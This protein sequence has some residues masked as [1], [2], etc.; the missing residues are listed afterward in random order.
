VVTTTQ[1]ALVANHITAAQ[2]GDYLRDHS[3]FLDTHPELLVGLTPPGLRTGRGVVDMQHF[4]INRLQRELEQHKS[5]RRDL[6]SAGRDNTSSLDRIHS[7]VLR[8]MEARTFDHLLEVVTEDLNEVL[9]ID[10]ATLCFESQ[11]TMLSGLKIN[12]LRVLPNGRVK[13]LMGDKDVILRAE[14]DGD[15]ALFGTNAR[16]VKSDA[17]VRIRI[18]HDGPDGLLAMGSIDQSRFHPGQGTELLA[19]LGSAL[20][21]CIRAW[22]NLPT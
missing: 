14:V 21:R 20:G 17:I 1:S 5:T 4:I 13:R 15:V 3:D 11:D 19:F 10:V 16:K 12:G 9:E 22:V 7:G 8:M 2:V 6:I 18:G